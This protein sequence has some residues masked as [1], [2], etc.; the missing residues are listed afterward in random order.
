[1]DVVLTD[2]WFPEGG[3]IINN[4]SISAHAPRPPIWRVPAARR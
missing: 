2:I 3:R 1:M 4:G